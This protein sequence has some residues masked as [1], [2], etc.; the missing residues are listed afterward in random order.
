MRLKRGPLGL[1]DPMRPFEETALAFASALVAGDFRKAR[2]LLSP[3]LARELSEADLRKELVAMLRGYAAGP[4][5]AVHFD[6]QFS[7]EEWPT[8]QTGDVGWAY[9]SITGHD[10]VEAVAVTVAKVGDVHKIRAIDW[11]RP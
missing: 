3:P 10:F 2:L 5:T 8:K 11:G 9:V 4:R 6:E 7:L 1:V